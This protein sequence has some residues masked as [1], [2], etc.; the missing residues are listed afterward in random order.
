METSGTG[1]RV[2]LLQNSSDCFTSN[3]IKILKTLLPFTFIHDESYAFKLNL[4]KCFINSFY[5]VFSEIGVLCVC[6]FF[7]FYLYVVKSVLNHMVKL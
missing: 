1:K 6:L 5:S 2:T 4:F 7:H 3:A